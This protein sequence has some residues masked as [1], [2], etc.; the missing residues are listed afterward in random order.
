M[1]IK[2]TGI[3]L[4][5]LA[6]AATG[7]LLAR[8][9]KRELTALGDFARLLDALEGELQT[10]LTPLPEL[11]LK[12]SRWTP[13]YRQVLEDYSRALDSQIAPDPE[14]CLE[15]ALKL[16]PELPSLGAK[17]LRLLGATLGRFDLPGQ[18]LQLEG[19][20]RACSREYS[21]LESAQEARLRSYPVLGLCAGV[22]LAILLL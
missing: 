9:Q 2:L 1:G 6:C 11:C 8:N 4:V 15:Y 13:T 5:F 12:A 16:R 17:Y 20:R 19:L 3:L 10:R 14:I 7:M 21:A 22:A 18:L